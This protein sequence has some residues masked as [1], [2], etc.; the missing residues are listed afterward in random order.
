VPQQLFE[1]NEILFF[2][3][4]LVELAIPIGR[5]EIKE[6]KGW[7]M[8]AVRLLPL[9]FVKSRARYVHETP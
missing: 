6:R 4:E 3:I 1:I 5:V 8:P 7:K 2:E 9:T